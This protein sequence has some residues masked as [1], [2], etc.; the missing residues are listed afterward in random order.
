M[1]HH[2]YLIILKI[3]TSHRLYHL[4]Q[5]LNQHWSNLRMHPHQ[6]PH[7][8]KELAE[9]YSRSGKANRQLEGLGGTATEERFC[10]D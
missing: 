7:R 2:L 9:A 8:V 5:K 3:Q 4:H 10:F 1:T 6:T